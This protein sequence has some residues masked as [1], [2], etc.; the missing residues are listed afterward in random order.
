MTRVPTAVPTVIPRFLTVAVMLEATPAFSR[1][2]AF[3][4]SVLFGL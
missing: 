3:M 2:N 4:I 1:G